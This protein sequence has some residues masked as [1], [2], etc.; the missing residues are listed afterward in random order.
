MIKKKERVLSIGQMV[1]NTM[2]IGKMVSNM[3]SE[4]IHQLRI[5]QREADGKMEKGLNG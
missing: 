5:K 3:E 2:V 1:E 4:F